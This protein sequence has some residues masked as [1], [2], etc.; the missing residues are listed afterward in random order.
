MTPVS[1]PMDAVAV[2]KILPHRYPFLLIDRILELEPGRSIRAVKCLSQNEAF[3]QGHFPEQ[4]VMPGV[5][6]VEALAQAGAVALL[7]L[8]ENEGKIVYLTGVDGFKFR[9]PVAPGDV[10]ELKVEMLRLRKGYGKARGVA[11]VDG[12]TAAEGEISFAV[13]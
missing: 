6:Q 11:S 8:P 12:E 9:R 7:M 10:L 3:L 13:A 4:P 5:L 2:R 1:L